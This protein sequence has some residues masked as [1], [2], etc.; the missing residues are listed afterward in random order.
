MGSAPLGGGGRTRRSLHRS[1]SRGGWPVAQEPGACQWID[2]IRAARQP[3]HWRMV[4]L[5]VMLMTMWMNMRMI[6][7]MAN[8]MANLMAMW[9]NMRIIMRMANLMAMLMV[10]MG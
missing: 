2:W 10:I 9:M 8:L 3:M 7:R 5:M 1:D 4:M 6:V